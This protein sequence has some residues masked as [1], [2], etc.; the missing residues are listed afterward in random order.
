MVIKRNK[1][2]S[3]LK[4]AHEHG[5]EWDAGTTNYAIKNGFVECLQYALHN[6]CPYDPS[7]NL[8]VKPNLV[9]EFL[10]LV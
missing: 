10:L 5:C 3:C 7:Y 6:G 4:Y 8:V 2:L 9:L 1:E